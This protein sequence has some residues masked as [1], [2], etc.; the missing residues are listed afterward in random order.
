MERATKED[1]E[2]F[3]YIMRLL[4]TL[5]LATNEHIS[6]HPM[7]VLMRYVFVQIDN[8]EKMVGRLKNR[9]VKS[10]HLRGEHKTEVESAIKKLLLSYRD[11]LDVIRDKVAAHGQYMEIGKFLEYWRFIDSTS[12]DVLYDDVFAL[13][14]S[15]RKCKLVDFEQVGGDFSP[16]LGAAGSPLN[17]IGR[18][19]ALA[20]DRAGLLRP[21]ATAIIPPRNSAIEATQLAVSIIDALLIDFQI[22]ALVDDPRTIYRKHMFDISW[23]MAI[24][25]TCSLIE[26]LFGG[27]SN[28]KSVVTLWNEEGIEGASLLHAI[29]ASR[30]K[31]LEEKL[32]RIRNSLAAHIDDKLPLSSLIEEYE[33][34]D[35]RQVWLYSIKLLQSFQTACRID[36]RTKLFACHGL[37]LTNLHSVTKVPSPF[38]S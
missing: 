20:A 19:P 10:G 33:R 32:R 23:Y 1:L 9:L 30:D 16:A 13:E 21:N 12:I 29:S 3:A 34:I 28:S 7:R 35:L 4:R 22:S 26:L 24:T 37:G 6:D 36:I 17:E 27:D 18:I 15:F 8:L 14:A 31:P 38:R 5:Y 11:S 2:K 25:D